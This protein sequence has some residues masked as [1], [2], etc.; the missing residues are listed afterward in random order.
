MVEI[1]EGLREPS[2]GEV[3][4]L[5]FDPTREP[6]SVQERIGAQ[7]QATQI[8][9]DLTAFEVLRLFA[10]FYERSLPVDDVLARV[11]LTAKGGRADPEPLGWAEAA[12]RHRH[13]AHPRSR[14]AHLR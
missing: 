14:P 7:L 9:A 8:P 5:G 3:S 2:S 13:G 12:A 6:L 11:N 10:A 4:V 1:L